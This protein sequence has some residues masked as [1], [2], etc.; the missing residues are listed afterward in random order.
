MNE[1]F[2][3][4]TVKNHVL[5]DWIR[6][7]I[8]KD[9]VSLCCT[10][11]GIK[12]VLDANY[13]VWEH[14]L[15]VQPLFCKSYRITVPRAQRNRC[16]CIWHL[17][18]WQKILAASSFTYLLSNVDSYSF[19][20]GLVCATFR[21]ILDL[22]CDEVLRYSAHK[23]LLHEMIS[24]HLIA[25]SFD[26]IEEV[27]SGLEALKV[28]GRPFV[29][30]T[31]N[32]NIFASSSPH[33][34]ANCILL[35]I[36][37][38]GNNIRVLEAAFNACTNLSLHRHHALYFESQGFIDRFRLILEVSEVRTCRPV[39]LAGL[40]ALR[41]IYDPLH[42]SNANLEVISFADTRFL[43]SWL[44]F[45]SVCLHFF[46]NFALLFF[47]NFPPPI[48]T[49]Y[50]QQILIDITVTIARAIPDES[51][52]I[53]EYLSHLNKIAGMLQL[54]LYYDITS[55]CYDRIT[56]Q[57]PIC[58]YSPHPTSFQNGYLHHVIISFRRCFAFPL[59]RCFFIFPFSFCLTNFLIC[60]PPSSY[61]SFSPFRYSSLYLLLL[62]LTFFSLYLS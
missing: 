23:L 42:I 17:Y 24:Q 4:E 26:D 38:Y 54:W 15:A 51:Y 19:A 3:F 1:G 13:S 46:R 28:L 53:E 52:V 36:K 34:T 57:R 62:S 59:F 32:P 10:S 18:I 33:I 8:S 49:L 61:S 40:N 14:C 11:R 16:F 2:S 9:V 39:L 5:F 29:N 7:L 60:S 47:L 43:Y 6:Y 55:P 58:V 31:V 56:L 44:T 25:T 37:T 12:E 22:S 45:H 50:W 21:R 27:T 48:F 20:S 30:I 41:N 35:S